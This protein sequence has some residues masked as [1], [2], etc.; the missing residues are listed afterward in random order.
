M[1]YLPPEALGGIWASIQDKVQEAGFQQFCD[2]TLLPQVKNLKVLTKD[3]TW[4][5][6]LSRFQKHWVY[7]V[8]EAY[9]TDEFYFDIG[10]ETCPQQASR[11]ASAA[12]Q[13]QAAAETLLYKRCCLEAYL[14]QERQRSGPGETQKVAFYPFS[15]LH[16]TGSLTIETGQRSALR[17]HGVLYRQFY[18]SNKEMFAAGNTY[19][20]TNPAIET[21]A[22]DKQLRKTWELV[23]GG[24]SH[25]PAALLKAYLYMKLRCHHA[26]QGSMEKS[27]GVREE[28]RI[29]K[30]L[31]SAVNEEIRGRGLH[32]KVL[33]VPTNQDSPYYSFRT[34]TVLRWLRWNINKFCVGFEMVY[35]FQDPHFVT[36]EHSRVMLM[37]LRCLQF[38]YGGGRIQASGGCWQDVRLQPDANHPHGVRRREGLGFQRTMK[39]HGYAWFLDKID[40]HTL[41]FKPPHAAYMLFDNPSLQAAYHRRYRQIRDVRIDFIRVDRARQWMLEFSA[42]PGCLAYLRTY[43]RQLCLCAFRKDVFLPLKPFLK[44][45]RVEAALAG[46]IPLCFDSLGDAL[47]DRYRL[48]LACG[49]RLAVQSVDV[50]FAWLWEWKD[51]QLERQG[52]DAKPYRMLYQQSFH[53]ISRAEGKQQAR[54]WRR[55]LKQSFLGSHWILPYPQKRAFMRKDKET[56]NFVWWPTFH[57]GLHDYYE[58]MLKWNHGSLSQPLP[59]SNIKHHPKDGWELASE[60]GSTHMPY[61]VQPEQSLLRLAENELYDELVR[62]RERWLLQE[63]V[64]HT[65]HVVEFNAL[66][67]N[68]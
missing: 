12:V 10:K 41:T 59:A 20:F 33:S 51:G 6:M 54:T 62:L 26:L 19:P 3:T 44:A 14:E 5:R 7:A 58:R 37:F 57:H 17:T 24:L 29:T 11:V 43:L 67:A 39:V 36:W 49:K 38:S 61:V 4:E 21:L 68:Y 32:N 48:Q 2:V 46:E 15:M 34:D 16:Q 35:S 47:D 25:Q 18:P 28:H 56:K 65:A 50:L 22:L 27:T 63:P 9:A 53:A 66:S 30:A 55:D 1:Y 42:V 31:L 64:R 40:W 52:W 45:E 23:G 60:F 13:G 8:D